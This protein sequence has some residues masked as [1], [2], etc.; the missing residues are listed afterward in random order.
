MSRSNNGSACEVLG[1]TSSHNGAAKYWRAW[2]QFLRTIWQSDSQIGV[3]RMRGERYL[4]QYIVPTVKFAGGIMVWGCFSCFGLGPL[5]PVKGYFNATAFHDI[6][7]TI[8]CFQ[9][10]G[11]SLGKALCCF[12]MAMPPMQKARSIKKWFVEI[13]VEELYWPAQSP[14]LNPI[15]HLWDVLEHRLRARPNH[16]IPVSDLTNAHGWMEASPRRN[17]PTSSGKP[18]QKSGGCYCSKGGINSILMS[19]ILEWDVWR[20]GVHI[21]LVR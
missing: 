18:S 9:L 6:L 10:C 3:W 5:V 21:L 4:P 19:M 13:G 8:L 20:A 2:W 14:D 17:V 12:S 16:P 15:K 7:E 11:N 1:H